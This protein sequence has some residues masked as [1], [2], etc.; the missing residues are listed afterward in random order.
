MIRDN[1]HYDLTQ[2]KLSN[3]IIDLI[4]NSFSEIA[5]KIINA[6]V[7]I[8]L[9]SEKDKDALLANLSNKQPNCRQ[10]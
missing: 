4:N 7:L 3:K 8:E 1:F 2:T 10:Y 9:E 5:D 6:L